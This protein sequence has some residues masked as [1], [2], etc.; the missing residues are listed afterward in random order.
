MSR[1]PYATNYPGLTQPRHTYEEMEAATP[2]INTWQASGSDLSEA[3]IDALTTYINQMLVAVNVFLEDL[4]DPVGR[5]VEMCPAWKQQYLN[6]FRK[7]LGFHDTLG[8]DVAGFK[9]EAESLT[10]RA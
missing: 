1:E 7:C 6:A 4:A 3:P 2:E 8:A 9:A 5:H 10:S